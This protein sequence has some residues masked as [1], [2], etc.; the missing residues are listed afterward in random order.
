MAIFRVFLDSPLWIF[1][2]IVEFGETWISCRG[3]CEAESGK[4][5]KERAVSG[6]VL[7]VL[8]PAWV[9]RNKLILV[10]FVVLGARFLRRR[11]GTTRN[12]RFRGSFWV[13]WR[14]RGRQKSKKI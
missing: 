3:F 6:V 12:A 13:S 2:E 8:E 9:S 10:V 7:G 4:R 11:N 1:V 14:P 5:D